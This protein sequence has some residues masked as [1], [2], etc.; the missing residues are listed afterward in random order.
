MQRNTGSNITTTSYSVSQLKQ[1][2]QTLL[3]SEEE[4]A[5]EYALSLY[6]FVTETESR[7]YMSGLSTECL[8]LLEHFG[9]YFSKCPISRK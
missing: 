5:I 8:I 7:T 2:I 1:R 9:E 6:V 3:Q 4:S